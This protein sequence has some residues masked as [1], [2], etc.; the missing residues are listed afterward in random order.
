MPA[1]PSVPLPPLA[2][3]FRALAATTVRPVTSI[4]ITFNRAVRGVTLDDFVLLRGR[5]AASLAGA[6][7][8][9]SDQITYTISSIRGTHLAGNYALRLKAQGTGIVDA[10]N[11]AVGG[12]AAVSWRMIRTVPPVRVFVPAIRR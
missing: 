7:I 10:L 3:T 4:T 1:P 6:R 8:T 5:G 12:P 11:Q 9:T 2:A